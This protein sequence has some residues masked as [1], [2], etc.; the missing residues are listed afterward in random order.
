MDSA[1]EGDRLIAAPRRPAGATEDFWENVMATARYVAALATALACATSTMAA[2]AAPVLA[3]PAGAPIVNARAGAV[4]GVAADGERVFKGVPYAL[5][6]VGARR[7][8]APA[9]MPAWRGVRDASAFGPACM[10]IPYAPNSLYTEVYPAMSEDCLTLNIWAPKNARRA[11]VM[12][13]IHGGSMVRGSSQE[14]I[15]DGAKLAARGIVVVSINYRLGLLGFLAHPELSAESPQG[16]SGNYAILDQIAALR[17]VQRNVAAFGG[18]PARVTITG[19]SAGGLSILYLLAS[20]EGRGLF[21]Q[22]IAQ[23][24][25]FASAPA[26]KSAVFG[27]PSAESAG[28][29]FA[30]AVGVKGIA[31]LRAMDSRAIIAAAVKGGFVP[32]AAVDGLVLKRQ[33]IE[34]FDRHEQARVPVLTG[35]NSGEIRTLRQLLPL[36]PAD[37]ASYEATI[38][39]RYGDQAAAFLR[40]YPSTTIEQSM[41]AAVRDGLF[42]WTSQQLV[43]SQAALGLPAYLYFWDHGYPAAEAAGLHGFHESE[44][45]YVFG[46]IGNTPAHWPKVG[47]ADGESALSEAMGDYWASFVRSGK[48]VAAHQPV[49]Q[50]FNKGG[51]YLRV[52]DTA[53]AATDLMP[54]Q[55][56][57]HEQ[58]VCRRHAAGTVQWNWGA[59]PPLPPATGACR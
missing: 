11:P 23:S 34:T 3:A 53:Q 20:P 30:A 18:D 55:F 13:W 2:P 9:A 44:V 32:T 58:V 45:P 37:A 47:D 43:R 22:A 49:W 48:P 39:S 40:Y 16:V 14:T 4:R 46:T 1:D 59:A 41:L 25:Y 7:W 17:W 56:A 33:L 52:G 26:L 28:E 57:L 51:A 10:Q 19:E 35:F 38:R 12:F 8:K 50:A 21:S 5:P 36:L 29:R 6:P 27:Q 31:D 24:A 54:G 42:G 15:F